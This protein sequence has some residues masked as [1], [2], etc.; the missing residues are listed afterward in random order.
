MGWLDLLYGNFEV[1][2]KMPC[3]L[4][5]SEGDPGEMGGV[6]GCSFG[7]RGPQSQVSQLAPWSPQLQHLREKKGTRGEDG[8]G[9]A[10][11]TV[12]AQGPAHTQMRPAPAVPCRLCHA[13]THMHVHTRLFTRKTQ[14]R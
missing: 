8:R 3:L 7:R 12:C 5:E 9:G 2:V 13:R 11:S 4:G 10:P 1:K 6:I 14:L